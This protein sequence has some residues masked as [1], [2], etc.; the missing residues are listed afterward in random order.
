[1]KLNVASALKL[2]AL[3]ELVGFREVLPSSQVPVLLIPL[4][5]NL[6]RTIWGNK[7]SVRGIS[8]LIPI[9]I[10][11]V[12]DELSEVNGEL[13]RVTLLKDSLPAMS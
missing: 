2:P 1:M 12:V 9:A 10:Y 8:S 4:P 3:P 5:G 7:F 13:N 6:F 11:S